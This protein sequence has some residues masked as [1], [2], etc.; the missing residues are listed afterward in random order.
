MKTYKI[1]VIWQM[2]GFCTIKA[3]SLE[4]AIEEAQDEPLPSDSS[5][6]EDSFE[7]DLEGAEIHNP[8]R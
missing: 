6:I 5:Y 7:V 3:E 2:A 4:D 1:P 8:D